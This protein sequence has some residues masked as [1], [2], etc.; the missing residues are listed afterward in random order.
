[1]D[2]SPRGSSVHGILQARIRGWVANPFFRG[3]S[4]LRD[5]THIS[6]TAGSSLT[7]WAIRESPAS[8]LSFI[9]FCLDGICAPLPSP[10]VSVSSEHIFREHQELVEFQ[11]CKE[12]SGRGVRYQGEHSGVFWK[13]RLFPEAR[14]AHYVAFL[15]SL[16]RRGPASGQLLDPTIQQLFPCQSHLLPCNWACP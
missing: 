5:Q 14:S 15:E 3:S 8:V 10:R 6:C 13:Q 9:V 4:R 7:I 16:R 12:G 2:C 1:M 11:C